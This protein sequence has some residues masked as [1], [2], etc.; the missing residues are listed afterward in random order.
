MKERAKMTGS[1]L[2]LYRWSAK[3]E[4][5]L[6]KSTAFRSFTQTKYRRG[7]VETVSVPPLP[8]PPPPPPLLLLLVRCILCLLPPLSNSHCHPHRSG[9][10]TFSPKGESRHFHRFCVPHDF[11]VKN[12]WPIFRARDFFLYPCGMCFKGFG[13]SE[14]VK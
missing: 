7:R 9:V 6:K 1:N 10:I 5:F 13:H 14:S 12:L 2:S 4:T 11:S 8:P 3:R